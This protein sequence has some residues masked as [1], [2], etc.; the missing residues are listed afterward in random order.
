MKDYNWSERI[1]KTISLEFDSPLELKELHAGIRMIEER[2][3]ELNGRQVKWDNDYWVR[4]DGDKVYLEFLV[5]K[6]QIE[7]RTLT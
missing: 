4:G 2:F 3:R 6:T 1:V 5:D 7:D